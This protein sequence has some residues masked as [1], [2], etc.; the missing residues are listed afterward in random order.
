VMVKTHPIWASG[1]RTLYHHRAGAVVEGLVT[2]VEL[3]A[4]DRVVGTKTT[5]VARVPVGATVVVHGSRMEGLARR[6]VPHLEGMA[7]HAW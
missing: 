4:L 6:P 7:M 5:G 3:E 2:L 1:R